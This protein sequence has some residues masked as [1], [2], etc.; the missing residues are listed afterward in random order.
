MFIYQSNPIKKSWGYNGIIS[1]NDNTSHLCHLGIQVLTIQ[2][3][4]ICLD[5]LRVWKLNN[6]TVSSCLWLSTMGCQWYALVTASEV[7]KMVVERSKIGCCD[8]RKMGISD[9]I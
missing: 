4:W 9:L 2:N 5:F 3:I 7:V 1:G 8:P 6:V